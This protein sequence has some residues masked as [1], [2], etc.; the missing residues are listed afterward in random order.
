MEA[1]LTQY[2]YNIGVAPTRMQ[3]QGMTQKGGESFKEYAQ[4]WRKVAARVQPPLL[5]KE[6]V[7]TFISTLHG[8]YYEKMIGSI[9]SNFA[10]LVTIGERVEEGIKSGKIQGTNAQAGVKKFFGGPPKRK[11][12]ETNAIS[13]NAS[14]RPP[15]QLPYSQYP[16]VATVAQGQYQ[17]PA[18]P[19][20]PPQQPFVMPSQNQQMSLQNQQPQQ[21]R[22]QPRNQSGPRGNFE[23]KMVRFDPVPIPYGQILPYLLQKGM[24]EPKPLAPLTPPYPPSYDANAKCEYHAGAP[25]HNIES[26]KAFKYKYKNFSIAS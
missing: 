21:N 11:E 24:V 15:V 7:D 12:G 10:D 3:L 18:Y 19:M 4:K 5:E 17:Q 23:R 9:S 8:P 20:H 1:F 26:C 22:Y 14:K 16:Y 13:D 25:G 2:K 6:L